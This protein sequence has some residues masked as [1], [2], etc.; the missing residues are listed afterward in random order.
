[1][2]VEVPRDHA[3]FAVH[4]WGRGIDAVAGRASAW[5]VNLATPPTDTH[6]Q[7]FW[8][9]VRA[10][11]GTAVSPVYS[12]RTFAD[13]RRN[14]I[15]LSLVATRVQVSHGIPGTAVHLWGPD[16]DTFMDQDTDWGTFL[17]SARR[18]IIADYHWQ[19]VRSNDHR[20]LSEERRI[21]GP[22]LRNKPILLTYPP[23]TNLIAS[24]D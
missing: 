17:V 9:A 4:I 22:Q 14:L 13:R 24:A 23:S 15:K 7:Y 5:R 16:V 6:Q 12:F 11:N 8:Q 10:K 2:G 21:P 19:I 3:D 18:P 20:P 1:M